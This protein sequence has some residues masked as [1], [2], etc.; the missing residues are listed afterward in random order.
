MQDAQKAI[1]VRTLRKLLRRYA[2]TNLRKVMMK[3]HPADIAQILRQM[4]GEEKVIL[5]LL[6]EDIRLAAAVLSEADEGTTQE[7]LK[8]IAPQRLAE[9]CQEMSPDKSADVIA[10]LSSE[11][12]Q[13]VLDIMTAAESEEVEEL[14]R[15]E[16][17]T[18]GGL[19]TTEFLALQQDMTVS[20]A[21]TAVRRASRAKEV[22]YLYVV[23]DEDRLQGVISLRQL[24]LA[25]PDRALHEV[26]I[27]HVW[28]VSPDVDQEA[29]AQMVSRYN[30]LA[31]PVVDEK[32]RLRGIITVDDIIDIIG[33]EATEDMLKMAGTGDEEI[34]SRSLLTSFRLRFPW[35]MATWGGGFVIV[36]I[37][38]HFRDLLEQ[39]VYLAAFMPIISGMG[40]NVGSQS[41][42]IVV[43]G[44]ATG[45][46]D[47]RQVARV[48]FKEQRVG[49][50]LGLCYGTLL[51]LAAW[52]EY[53]RLD[54]L[55]IVVGVA[56][57][58]SM[59]LSA[60]VASLLPLIL[61]RLGV[62]PAVATGPIVSTL[63]DML[64]ITLYFTLAT[65]L[66][67]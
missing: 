38:G 35:L 12:A 47:L 11:T 30:I 29:V 59:T 44:L 66:L 60:T 25:A 64:S 9:I 1:I 54:R 61:R 55:S 23:D 43:R 50:V 67:L 18:A 63:V 3:L 65:I 17:E 48:V 57:F 32:N 42:T 21:V 37:I 24:L 53:G 22:F 19:M 10:T 20:E 13:Q 58:I 52:I 49:L 28:K 31:L 14:L 4:E 45:H 15:Y 51:G 40:G 41:A 2:I 34:V 16:E 6:L 27:R 36:Q 62:D 7:I 46:I 26:M 56:L 39:L 8:E 5:F 33:S